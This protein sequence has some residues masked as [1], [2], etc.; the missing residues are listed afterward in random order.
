MKYFLFFLVLPALTFAQFIDCPNVIL[1]V[2]NG[3]SMEDCSAYQFFTKKTDDEQIDTPG[4]QRLANMGTL[5]TDAHTLSSLP[6][7]SDYSLLTG[8][9]PWRGGLAMNSGTRTE[10]RRGPLLEEDRPTLA[11]LFR[12]QGYATT[13]VG[14]W[15]LGIRFTQSDARPAAGWNDADL[16]QDIYDGPCDH[17]FTHARFKVHTNPSGSKSTRGKSSESGKK[18]LKINYSKQTIRSVHIHNRKI[19]GTRGYEK[20]ISQEDKRAHKSLSHGPPYFDHGITF[21]H[22]HLRNRAS[23]FNPF[24]LFYSGDAQE[25]TKMTPNKD[26]TKGSQDMPKMISGQPAPPHLAYVSKYEA[27][28][29]QLLDF[30]EKTKD[31]RRP[32][33]KLIHNTLVI[34][35]SSKGGGAH[36]SSAPN[37]QENTNN[38][39]S[40]AEL[41]VPFIASWPAGEIGNGNQSSPGQISNQ[42]MGLHQLY[43]T[44]SEILA[45][46]LPNL[47]EGE[48]G[49]EDSTN[50]LPIWSGTK[51]TS[52]QPIFYH[53][54][55]HSKNKATYTM[56]MKDP[57]V[58][59]RKIKGIW[60]L[61]WQDSLFIGKKVKSAKLFKISARPADTPL[62]YN[63]T[64]F[65]AIKEE[66][67]SLVLLYHS[68][69]GDRFTELTPSKRV[70][71]DWTKPIPAPPPVT[72]SISGKGG[73]PLQ[74][75]DGL[76]IQG[77]I[78]D[79]IDPGEAVALRFEQ[80]VLVESISFNA[81]NGKFGGTIVIGNRPPLAIHP[82]TSNHQSNDSIGI[83]RDLGVVKKDERI[84]LSAT[85][86]L[87]VETSGSWK[88]SSLVVRPFKEN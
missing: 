16:T 37:T 7:L 21:L 13:M 85:P 32:S 22:Q 46:P 86:Y 35:T 67:I 63:D 30:L 27:E 25:K 17:G 87:G 72:L 62:K 56:S 68:S 78:S 81:R 38:T 77:K 69:G 64:E 4:I 59:G 80:D 28:L 49:A 55:D 8:R 52:A 23:S 58:R 1:F 14:N 2:A 70:I 40:H 29:E 57:L 60:S 84:I 42:L 51:M 18:D 24:F 6:L 73:I 33:K 11:T 83:L 31:P 44:F 10:E 61:S 26:R 71:F 82:A 66:F 12:S 5:H 50:I 45:A 15:Q 48:K 41:P 88:L 74:K 39:N 43:A 34:F 54:H 47:R 20:Q 19:I 65:R 76:G 53:H 9:Y 3:V 36:P 79:R 75:E